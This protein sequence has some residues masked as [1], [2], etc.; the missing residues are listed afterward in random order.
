MDRV[1]TKRAFL[2]I[3]GRVECARFGQHREQS[4]PAAVL[5][6]QDSLPAKLL[7]SLKIFLVFLHV[8][9]PLESPFSDPYSL[10]AVRAALLSLTWELW[11]LQDAKR[12][13]VLI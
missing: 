8:P 9:V 3:R 2:L 6:V 13:L 11:K 12:W 1:N 10:S 4:V 7:A 5:E